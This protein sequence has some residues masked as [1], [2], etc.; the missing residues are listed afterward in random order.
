M[1]EE[2]NNKKCS[3]RIFWAFHFIGAITTIILF[4]TK[5]TFLNAFS[6]VTSELVRFA[7]LICYQIKE[8]VNQHEMYTNV[9]GIPSTGN[10]PC[11]VNSLEVQIQK[12]VYN[13]TALLRNFVLFLYFT[14]GIFS[15]MFTTHSCYTLPRGMTHIKKARM[16]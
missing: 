4:I 1:T 8:R 14:L 7:G 13:V 5:P 9:K 10:F 15:N 12:K 6:V 11:N 16:F 3:H 2:L